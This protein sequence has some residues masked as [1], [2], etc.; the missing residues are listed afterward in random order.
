MSAM[1]ETSGIPDSMQFAIKRLKML[2]KEI[3]PMTPNKT[4]DVKP[5]QTIMLI[6]HIIVKLTYLHF[7]GF[8]MELP[9]I[10]GAAALMDLPVM[11]NLVSSRE[12]RPQSFRNSQ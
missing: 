10:T 1:N 11:F 2:Q 7:L 9:H 8:S 12:I 3:V 5:G 4:T 6:Y